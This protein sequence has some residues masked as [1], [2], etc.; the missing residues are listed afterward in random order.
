MPIADTISSK[1]RMDALAAEMAMRKREGL[2]TFRPRP[3]QIPFH[4][5]KAFQRV[6]RGGNRSGKTV[7]AVAE[8]AAAVLHQPIVTW[9]GETLPLNYPPPPLVVWAIGYDQRHLARMYRKLCEPGLY[10]IIKD[11][12]TGEWR[13]WKP[14][15]PEEA[16]KKRL[17]RRS[18][19]LIPQRAIAH[20][21]WESKGEQVPSVIELKNGTRIFFFPSGGE[22]GVGEAVDIVWIDEDIQIP[23]HV[24]EW[25]ARL[26]D[27]EGRLIW[28]SWP[29]DSNEALR[30]LVKQ[31]EEQAGQTNPDVECWT[32]RFSDNPYIPD[33]AK[34]KILATWAAAGE[35]TLLARDQGLFADGLQRVFPQFDIE[36]HGL[37]T[38][39]DPDPIERA[40]RDAPNMLPDNWT[41]YLALDPGFE[42]IAAVFAMVPPPNLGKCVVIRRAWY[43]SRVD[44]HAVAQDIKGEFPDVPWQAFIM[45]AHAGRTHTMGRGERVADVF[46]EA[47]EQAKLESDTTGYAF[48]PGSDDVSAR[49]M[50]VRQWLSE[51]M[52]GRPRFRLVADDTY[53]MQREFANY[54]CR[55]GRDDTDD[56]VKKDNHTMD[57]NGYLMAYLNPLFAVEEAWVAPRQSPYVDPMLKLL[58]KMEGRNKRPGASSSFWLGPG[59]APTIGATV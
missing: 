52:N 31:A 16:G 9:E 45:D 53:A 13:P 18:V 42:H 58:K 51:T 44:H 5:S 33:E 48:I 8:L 46:S 24:Q 2:S 57:C 7:A 49:N 59:A 14:W 41:Y 3:T 12:A 4:R 40:V 35:A 56:V 36:T 30:L 32:L 23:S 1:N 27:N 50:I 43:W 20:I 54:K 39:G 11:K 38:K 21:A 55:V 19:P 28:S 6:V 26:A 34:R 22:A 17:T 37:V 10:R 29:K 25:Q 15:E 47:F